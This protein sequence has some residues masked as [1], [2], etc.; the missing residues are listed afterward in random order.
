MEF[1]PDGV[2]AR[3][4]TLEYALHD[5]F[6]VHDD[7]LWSG[8]PAWISQKQFD[9]EAKF[10]IAQY[11]HPSLDQRRAMLQHLLSDRFKLRVH[12]QSRQFPLYALVITNHGPKL[13]ET[14]PENLLHSPAYG[15]MCHYLRSRK[16]VM[17]ISGCTMAD[18]A[19]SLSGLDLGRK[20][21]DQT[22]L[23]GHYDLLLHWSPVETDSPSAGSTSAIDLGGPSIFTA[24]KEQLGLELKP[25]TGPL[26]TIV[27]DHIEMPSEN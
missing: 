15:V 24:V 3:G 11:P 6:G 18:L 19:S 10:D 5:A 21:V 25:I 17:E 26:D 13:T 1:T 20:V 4:V 14:K 22:A 8:G 23:K 16:G 9:I 7:R 12:H 27:I 2:T